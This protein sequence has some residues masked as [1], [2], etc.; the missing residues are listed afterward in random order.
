[1]ARAPLLLLHNGFHVGAGAGEVRAHPL[2]LMA[3]DHE[4]APGIE[5]SG[6]GQNVV[7][8]GTSTEFVEDLRGLRLHPAAL[9]SGKD[10][11]CG[12]ARHTHGRL[13]PSASRM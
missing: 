8:E 6:G 9:T 11:D 7:D 5:A 4:E 13:A 12:R 10:D 1:M 3:D 2:T